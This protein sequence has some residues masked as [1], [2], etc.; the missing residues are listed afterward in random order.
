MGLKVSHTE[1]MCSVMGHLF[2]H[3]KPCNKSVF[4]LAKKCINVSYFM[5]ADK[6]SEINR[7]GMVSPGKYKY[8]SVV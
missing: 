2:P 3:V 8:Y 5:I 4:S 7:H 1:R 6:T